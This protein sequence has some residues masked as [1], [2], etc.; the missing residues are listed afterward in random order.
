MD[1]VTDDAGVVGNPQG[2]P[3]DTQ[4]GTGDQFT[5]FPI[6]DENADFLLRVTVSVGDPVVSAPELLVELN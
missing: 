5:S 1:D 6:V 2:P 3:V 4:C